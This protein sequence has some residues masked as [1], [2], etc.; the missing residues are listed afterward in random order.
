MSKGLSSTDETLFWRRGPGPASLPCSEVHIWRLRLDLPPDRVRQACRESLLV[1]LGRYAG[2]PP[3]Q[4]RLN[5]G[6]FGKPALEPPA[7]GKDIQFNLS[8][9]GRVALIALAAGRRVG[10]DVEEIRGDVRMDVLAQDFFSAQERESLR[11]LE[12]EA[13]TRMFYAAWTRREAAI[14]AFGGSVTQ[15]APGAPAESQWHREDMLVG[16]GYV[17]ALCCEGTPARILFWEW[18]NA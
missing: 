2:L 15:P 18:E 17:A 6:P 13:K 12:G 3:G 4:V 10:V 7:G 16:E 8:H 5:S 1:L 11:G 14:K 9:S